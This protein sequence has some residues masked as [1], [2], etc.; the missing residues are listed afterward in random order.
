MTTLSASFSTTSWPGR[1]V[2][3]STAGL[4]LT[5]ILRPPVKTS[6]V[7]S[8]QAPRNTPKPEG[9][10]ASRSTSSFS[11]TIWSRAS[12]SVSAR[13]SFWPV[14]E[15]SLASAS[16]SRSSTRRACLGESASLRRRTATSSSRKEICVVRPLTWSS[17][18]AESEPSSRVATPPPPSESRSHLDPTYPQRAHNRGAHAGLVI[19]PSRRLFPF[20]GPLSRPAPPG[21]R[22]HPL[23]EPTRRHQKAGVGDHPVPGPH[24]EPVHVPAA[25][26]RLPGGRLVKAALL[27][28]RLHGPRQLGHG[29]YVAADHTAT[30]QHPGGGADV[31][32]GRHHVQHH[33]VERL[34][35]P[36]FLMLNGWAGV[37]LARPA[38]ATGGRGLRGGGRR[39]AG[40]VADP[41]S[42]GRVRAAE[43]PL[44]VLPRDAGEVGP[45]LVGD[46]QPRLPGRP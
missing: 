30:D 13:R 3:S 28:D 43:E 11:A 21:W 18:R 41:Q 8:S 29:G 44:D 10:L 34:V 19:P 20:P 39:D 17:C 42:P 26:E 15:E 12:R 31:L 22:N 25:R 35:S 38:R 9:G 36:G 27:P 16:R 37:T 1:R 45:A 24:R 46:Q 23:G 40:Q 32:P 4:T 6:A 2:S 7:P 14:T 33:A 5:R